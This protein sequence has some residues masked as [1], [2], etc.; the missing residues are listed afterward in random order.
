MTQAYHT[1]RGTETMS[2]DGAWA[3]A[4]KIEAYWIKRRYMGV[5]AHVINFRVM[6]D[7][8]HE[9]ASGER[10][11]IWGVRSNI[12][13]YGFPPRERVAEVAVNG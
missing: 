7:G 11:N 8:R 1:R 5:E 6:I 4:R 3:L 13:P 2:Y 10:W 9:G 12:G